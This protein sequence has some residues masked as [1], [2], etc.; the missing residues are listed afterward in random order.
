[1]L[2]ETNILKC[3]KKELRLK[4]HN[5]RNNMHSELKHCVLSTKNSIDK[6]VEEECILIKNMMVEKHNE[7]DRYFMECK[8]YLDNTI[9]EINSE[10]DKKMK[11]L[12]DERDR[13]LGEVEHKL[14]CIKNEVS[15]YCGNAVSSLEESKCRNIENVGVKEKKI[16]CEIEQYGKDEVEKIKKII[17]SIF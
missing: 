7:L 8:K 4:S 12:N 13:R 10:M 5:I 11:V 6:K 2:K 1:M 14:N 16:T 3:L 17:K 9:V 15:E